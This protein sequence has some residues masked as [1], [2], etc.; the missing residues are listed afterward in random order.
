MGYS[1]SEMTK[2]ILTNK[3]LLFIRDSENLPIRKMSLWDK[4]ANVRA[5]AWT[6][7]RTYTETGYGKYLRVHKECSHTFYVRLTS[8]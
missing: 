8:I 6:R 4:F 7:Y 5:F 1:Q 2:Y 3:R